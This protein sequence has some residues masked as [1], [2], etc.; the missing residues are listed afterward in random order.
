MRIV[1][2][3]IEGHLLK[4]IPFMNADH[5]PFNFNFPAFQFLSL[6]CCLNVRIIKKKIC[7][8]FYYY[9][10]LKYYICQ[11]WSSPIHGGISGIS[12]CFLLV[13][14]AQLAVE[15]TLEV[16]D[17]YSPYC[18]LH[19][20]WYVPVQAQTDKTRDCRCSERFGGV[21]F[22]EMKSWRILLQVFPEH[23]WMVIFPR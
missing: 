9:Y 2:V 8:I 1:K 15:I 12:V 11:V 7:Y 21:D 18:Y 20:F 22:C 6:I 13:F 23:A 3:H 16:K 4:R 17:R 14:T 5:R 19:G 10:Y